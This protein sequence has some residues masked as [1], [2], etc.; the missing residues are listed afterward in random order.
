MFYITNTPHSQRASSAMPA[1]RQS[2]SNCLIGSP[3]VSISATMS[4]EAQYVSLILPAST[5][6]RMKSYFMSWSICLVLPWTCGF[7]ARHMVDWLSS[8]IV[9]SRMLLFNR[10]LVSCWSHT[11]SWAAADK[12]TYSASA[13][14]R[15]TQVCLL[16]FQLIAAPP[17]RNTYPAVDFLSPTSPAQSASEHKW[18][19]GIGNALFHACFTFLKFLHSSDTCNLQD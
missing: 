15:A 3:L 13:V 2:F 6:S 4:S 1:S 12:V 8:R 10:S 17:R 18:G 16:L 9:V 14:D 5:G 11:A 19:G 7:L